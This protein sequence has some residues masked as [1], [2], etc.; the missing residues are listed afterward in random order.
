[1]DAGMARVVSYD[2]QGADH[3]PELGPSAYEPW[4]WMVDG[5]IQSNM[6]MGMAGIR[7]GRENFILGWERAM[8]DHEENHNDTLLQKPDHQ[9]KIKEHKGENQFV[10][11]HY[12]TRIFPAWWAID[13]PSKIRKTTGFLRE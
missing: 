1:M 7:W 2:D 13:F 9:M 10:W 12:L 11:S 8:G 4:Y 6:T 5:V 3:R